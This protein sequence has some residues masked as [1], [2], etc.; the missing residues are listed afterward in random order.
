[1]R[2]NQYLARAGLGSRRFC[3]ELIR[4]GRVEVN[5]R[6]VRELHI[7]VGPAEE[8][9][10][11][12]RTVRPC[13]RWVVLLHK[14]RGY[15]CTSRDPQGRK[16]IFELLP[17]DL[18]RLFY[19]GRLDRQ[20]E[21]LVLL[22]NDG[23]LAQAISRPRFKI[24]KRYQVWVDRPIGDAER[25]LLCQGIILE[26]RLC[27]CAEVRQRGDR[28]LE[29]V[30]EEGAKRQIRRMLE[31]LGYRVKRLIRTH[32]GGF[33]LRG[34]PP[35]AWRKVSPEELQRALNLGCVGALRA[36]PSTGPG[37]WALSYP[38]GYGENG[39]AK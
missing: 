39:S 29:I 11:D 6:V 9:K 28:Q 13:P 7:R 33:S 24:P 20:S 21:G 4:A 16:T 2:L 8:V 12:G 3:E 10:L 36:E 17:P 35:G 14:P 19:V 27:R 1:M 22:T 38:L 30:L 32:I 5:G 23:I 34:L 18:P 37:P 26:G 15:L 25:R 31:K